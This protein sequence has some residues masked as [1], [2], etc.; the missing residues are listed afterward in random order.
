MCQL[1]VLCCVMQEMLDMIWD[2]RIWYC[3]YYQLHSNWDNSDKRAGADGPTKLVFVQ[4]IV[5]TEQV[6]SITSALERG[7]NDVG[8]G[9]YS[10]MPN[11]GYRGLSVLQRRN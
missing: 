10:N 11:C 2:G 4:T 5:L 7:T 8:V 9:T 1:A 6:P 3:R